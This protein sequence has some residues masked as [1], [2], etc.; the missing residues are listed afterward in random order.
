MKRIVLF[1]QAA[2]IAFFE[3][4]CASGGSDPYLKT[5]HLDREVLSVV[6][7]VGLDDFY[8]FSADELLQIDDSW[9]L[10]SSQKGLYNLLFLNIESG[11]G[12]YAIRKGRGPGEM[13]NG[14]N[15]HLRDDKA[16]YYDMSTAVCISIDVNSFIEYKEILIDTLCNFVGKS[17]KPVYM[18]TCHGGIVSGNSADSDVW[19]SLYGP[20]GEVSSSVK[21]LK[22]DE[23]VQSPDVRASVMLSS[24]Y[25]SSP[26]GRKV[27]VASVASPS[28]SF[29]DV[30][31]GGLVEYLRYEISPPD[32]ERGIS[33]DNRTA[34]MD[35]VA[36][37]S[38]VYF[39]Y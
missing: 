21:A 26:D 30:V 11:N 8:D 37:G 32:M 9:M 38:F 23:L 24:K 25:A 28:I 7:S 12:I 39:L 14:G 4:S 29:A 6:D 3:L 31:D 17:P 22:Y 10:L 15:L 16:L 19:Y 36:D 20:D 34:F 18:T 35:V 27:C 33:A 13:I 5:L 2:I 1:C